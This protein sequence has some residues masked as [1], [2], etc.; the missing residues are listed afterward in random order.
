MGIPPNV[1]E[2]KSSVVGRQGRSSTGCV[3]TCV[4]NAFYRTQGRDRNSYYH[5]LFLRGLPH[6]CKE[7]KRPGVSEKQAADP[8]LEPDFYKISELYPVPEKAVEDDSVLLHF[9]LQHGP[10]A[11]MPIYSGGYDKGS[12]R[13]DRPAANSGLTPRDHDA[14]NAFQQS[15]GAAE[16]Q[17]RNLNYSA[18]PRALDCFEPIP[19]HTPPAV[20][21]SMV[22][23]PGSGHQSGGGLHFQVGTKVSALA[24]ANQLA[25][26][27]NR[28]SSSPSTSS[29]MSQPGA[30]HFAAGFA[31]AQA[32]S[33]QQLRNIM[34][35]SQRNEHQQR[36]VFQ[37]DWSFP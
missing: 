7:M 15:L 12:L 6:L 28:N 24:T 19:I 17:L 27:V 16:S 33:Q 34:I 36:Q 32:L 11:R 22:N 8:E 9:T 35:Q 1:S 21:A 5:P 10:K 4:H 26:G 13:L 31:A 23:P 29:L 18:S 2:K 37:K 25:F 20:N 30:A 3:L 14:L